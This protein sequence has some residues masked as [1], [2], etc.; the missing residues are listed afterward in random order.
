MTPGG[1]SL[2][3]ACTLALVVACGGDSNE[4][5]EGTPTDA[6]PAGAAS[7]PPVPVTFTVIAGAAQDAYD[8]ESFMPATVR[9][10]EGDSIAWNGSGYEGHTVTFFPDGRFNFEGGDYLIDAPDEPGAK[11]FNPMYA[12]QSTAQGSYDGSAYVNSGFFGVPA[13]GEYTLSFPKAGTYPY[14]CMVHALVMRGVVI[15]EEADEQVP[16]PEAVAA[17]GEAQLERYAE[18]AGKAAATVTADRE[19]TAESTG[20]DVYEVSVGIDTPQAQV[21]AFLPNPLEIDTGDKVVFWNSD[22]DFHNVVFAPDE[23]E[24]PAFPLIKPGERP[25]FRLLINPEAAN[26][27]EPP[28]DFGPEAYFSSGMM[29]IGWPRMYYEVVFT[30]PGTYQYYCTVHAQAGM[31]GTVTVR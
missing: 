25:P 10:R 4:Q 15:V 31:A 12:L 27:I 5:A 8:I 6:S 18:E 13:P 19:R 11:E 1:F 3:L 30:R 28:P 2:F 21:L 20:G 26:E 7:A 14:I 29:G 24:L 23:T 17:E 9:I 16:A 22:R